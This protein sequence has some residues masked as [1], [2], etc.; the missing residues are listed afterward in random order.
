MDFK[1]KE[2]IQ[3]FNTL[4]STLTLPK[5]LWVMYEDDIR[6]HCTDSWVADYENMVIAGEI[7]YC[8][9]TSR[10]KLVVLKH[11][12]KT[13][14]WTKTNTI[15][16]PPNDIDVT[17]WFKDQLIVINYYSDSEM[18]VQLES[19]RKY[20]CVDMKNQFRLTVIGLEHS[21]KFIKHYKNRY[22]YTAKSIN[23]GIKHCPFCGTNLGGENGFGI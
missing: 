4:L 9:V 22:F 20:C 6:K 21:T 7:L 10:K 11:N 5:Q 15:L 14:T 17:N 13:N 8:L 16:T 2:T 23:V 12:Y 18:Y 19:P 3:L 1:N